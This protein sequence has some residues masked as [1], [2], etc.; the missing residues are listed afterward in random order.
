MFDIERLQVPKFRKIA[1]EGCF[2]YCYLRSKDSKTGAMGTPYYV[3]IASTAQR[4]VCRHRHHAPVPKDRRFIRVLRKGLSWDEVCKW[5][6]RY[7][8]HYGRQNTGTGILRNLTDGGEG[9]RGV[10]VSE[11]TRQKLREKNI[12]KKLTEE[13][14]RR[15]GEA[16]RERFKDGLTPQAKA[17]ISRAMSKANRPTAF[18][19]RRTAQL[20]AINAAR[21]GKPLPESTRRRISELAMGHEVSQETR[22]K[23]SARN[24]GVPKPQHWIETMKRKG[25]ERFASDMGLPIEQCEGLTP[26]QRDVIRQRHAEGKRGAELF[27]KKKKTTQ[28]KKP[29]GRK[30][31]EQL[32]PITAEG[33]EA[34]DR[35]VTAAGSGAKLATELDFTR[36][37]V[38]LHKK[39]LEAMT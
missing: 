2:V 34:F 18:N 5:E 38:S 10:V 15:I 33:K 6:Q 11:A 22:D 4:P 19:Q 37:A 30:T 35:A 31:L 23:I 3:G 28:R 17:K 13:A 9:S 7:I 12:G 8:A 16:S 32:F 29:K 27:E 26:S 20:K 1:K 14:K 25:L 24:R 39:K 21:V 36:Q